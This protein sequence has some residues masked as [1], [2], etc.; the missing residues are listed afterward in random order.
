MHRLRDLDRRGRWVA[1]GLVALLLVP[2]AA[3]VARAVHQA[4]LPSGDDALIGLRSL[5]VWSRHLPLVGQPSTSHLYGDK[6]STAHPGP[7]EFYWL[8]APVKLF[9]P[10]IGMILGSGLANLAGVAVAAWVVFRRAGPAAGAWSLVV[11]GGVL[12]SEGTAL[13][14]DPISSN[15]GGLPLLALAALAWA[16]ADGDLR[17]LPLAAAF[18]SWVAQQ[19]LAIVAPAATMVA[20]A[21]AGAV[22]AVVA[23]RRGRSTSRAASTEPGAPAPAPAPAREQGVGPTQGGPLVFADVDHPGSDVQADGAAT[24]LEGTGGGAASRGGQPRAERIWPWVAGAAAVVAVCWWP[25]VWQQLTGHPGN[26]TAVLDYAG[27]STQ[28]KLGWAAGVRQGARALGLPP[29]L[30]RSD[31]GG[32]DFSG[33]PLGVAEAV[34]AAVGYLVLA[35]TVVVGWRRRR[36]LALLAA[37]ALVL[38]IGGVYNG[39]SI[40]DS[41]EA[42]RVNFYRWTFVVAWLSWIVFGW[43]AAIG[44]R[45]LVNRQVPAPQVSWGRVGPVL[46][47]VALFLPAVGAVATA[48]RDDQRRDQAGFAIMRI[49]ADA[50]VAEAEGHGRVTLVLRGSSA[51]LASGPALTM[52]LTAQ[53]H[54]VVLPGVEARFYGS[55]RVLQPGDDPGDIVLQLVTG[56]G[57]VPPGPG[58]VIAHEDLNRQL[59]VALA[60]LATEARRSAVRVAPGGDRLLRRFW[61]KED[62]RRFVRSLLAQVAQRPEAVLGDAKLLAVVADGYFTSPRFD[63]DRLAAAARRLPARTVNQDDVFEVRVLTRAELAEEVPSWA[64]G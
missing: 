20:L 41:I 49:A 27:A 40:P 18:G 8:A 37:T 4:W 31:L 16:V 6:V 10:A 1:V 55:H 36:P 25:V 26:I 7:I 43:L 42:F 51:I 30:V 34:A 22:L 9:G 21:V 60:P 45:V 3:S 5:D 64:K 53:G 12:W 61:P 38:A 63:P 32:Q 35:V 58:R 14:T 62:E 47:A 54:D 2:F 56:R 11:L 52:A 44:A 59:N 50:A 24:V 39:H 29:L 28:A 15:A 57:S 17:L 46:A 33:A 13:L 23:Q 19:H 48:G